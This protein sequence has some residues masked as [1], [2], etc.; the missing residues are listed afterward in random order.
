MASVDIVTILIIVLW[1]FPVANI[2]NL[3]NKIRGA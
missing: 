3:G 1:L 2:Y